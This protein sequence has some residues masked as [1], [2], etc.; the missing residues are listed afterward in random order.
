MRGT[1]FAA[2]SG[3]RRRHWLCH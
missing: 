2:E 1:I 3:G